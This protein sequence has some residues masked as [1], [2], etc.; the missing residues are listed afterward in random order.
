MKNYRGPRL[1]TKLLLLGLVLLVIPYLG[2]QSLRAMKNFLF[3]GQEQA[4]LMT[5]QG[6]ATLLHG[7][8]ELFNDTPSSVEGYAELPIFPLETNIQLDAFDEEWKA[9][10]LK[11]KSQT[12][13]GSGI[14]FELVLGEREGYIYGL[15][16]VNDSTPVNR[17]HKLLR[18]DQ[19][20]HVRFYFRDSEGNP[21]RVQMVWEGSGRT[22]AILWMR[23]GATTLATV[24][25]R[26][27][28]KA[29]SN[30]AATIT[31]SSFASHST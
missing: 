15:L 31:P 24:C 26:I 7:R 16:Q 30:A 3:K 25:P 8:D 10:G 11:R 18:L 27:A 1:G 2:T 22:T 28:S 13:P 21:Q 4:Q 9:Y 5:A 17:T 23:S 14:F 6:I 29:I 20:D 12:Y 19:S